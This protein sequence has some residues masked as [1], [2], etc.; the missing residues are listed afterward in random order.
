MTPAAQYA[1]KHEKAIEFIRANAPAPLQDLLID[2]LRPSIAFRAK[3]VDDAQIPIGASKFG[4]A[5]DVP[6]GFEWPMWDEEPLGFL[7]QIN[8]EEV[9]AFDVEGLLP[10][11]G[12]LL[13]FISFDEE[14]PACCDADQPESW[15]VF[16]WSGQSIQRS[17]FSADGLTTLPAMSIKP[18]V[19]WTLPFVS[20]IEIEACFDEDSPS[21]CGDDDNS[22]YMEFCDEFQEKFSAFFNK[23]GGW[24][25]TLQEPMGPQCQHESERYFQTQ[26]I[27]S[28]AENEAWRFI[29]QFDSQTYDEDWW[30]Y[31]GI[32][33]FWIQE[34]DLESKNFSAMWMMQQAS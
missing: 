7:A 9:A 10:K 29:F 26:D 12:L 25:N 13:F 28:E 33:Y 34:R 4:G 14:N 17:Q 5:P 22:D 15:Q 23:I 18:K 30:P 31:G 1:A 27:P 21:Y 16:Y 20:E 11:S 32:F 6:E 19:A 8:L 2:L 24:P 3:S